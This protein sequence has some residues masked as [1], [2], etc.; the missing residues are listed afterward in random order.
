MA[1]LTRNADAIGEKGNY[2]KEVCNSLNDEKIS[3]TNNI[4][5][6]LENYKGVDAT[7]IANMLLDAINKVDDL[8]KNLSY[9]SN[10]MLAVAKYDNENIES[11]NK[12]INRKNTMQPRP[13]ITEGGVV[14][15]S[16]QIN[17]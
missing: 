11:A 15:E 13:I 10:Y 4:N 7:S 5:S 12:K 8:I 17:Y 16:E 9:Y 3:F 2:L 6:M 14:N 1:R